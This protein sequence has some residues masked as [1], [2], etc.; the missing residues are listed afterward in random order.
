V[1]EGD[2]TEAQ[3]R[4]KMVAAAQNLVAAAALWLAGFG[5]EVEGAEERRCVR[6]LL[7]NGEAGKGEHR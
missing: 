4:E 1:T 3:M 5:H 7:E 6:L 2:I